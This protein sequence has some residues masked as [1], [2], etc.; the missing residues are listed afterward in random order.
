M[1][2]LTKKKIEREATLIKTKKKGHAQAQKIKL[3]KLKKKSKNNVA[4]NKT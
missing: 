3:K 4:Q 1:T 2:S